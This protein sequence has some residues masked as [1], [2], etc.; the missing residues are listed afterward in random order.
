MSNLNFVSLHI[1]I[2]HSAFINLVKVSKDKIFIAKK[3]PD[4]INPFDYYRAKFLA[5]CLSLGIVCKSRKGQILLNSEFNLHF[6]LFISVFWSQNFFVSEYKRALYLFFSVGWYF[7]KSQIFSICDL[8]WIFTLLF[9]PFFFL[10]KKIFLVT[11]VYEARGNLI[12]QGNLAAMCHKMYFDRD[13]SRNFSSNLDILF[14]FLYLI[15]V[16][17]QNFNGNIF[18]A[19]SSDFWM[20]YFVKLLSFIQLKLW[21]KIL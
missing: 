4:S 3:S 2:S 14:R 6:I 19:P 13:G 18:P 16:V 5:G 7:R 8:I 10:K 9:N 15:I 17:G 12:E 1:L 20:I 11:E 21:G